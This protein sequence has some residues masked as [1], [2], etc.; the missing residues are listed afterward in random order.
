[1]YL[2][3]HVYC[4]LKLW[5]QCRRIRYNTLLCIISP[6]LECLG[7]M[8][9]RL[10]LF[11]SVIMT[12]KP[13]SLMECGICIGC[14]QDVHI[15]QELFSRPAVINRPRSVSPLWSTCWL[16]SSPTKALGQAWFITPVLERWSTMGRRWDVLLLLCQVIESSLLSRRE[17]ETHSCTHFSLVLHESCSRAGGFKLVAHTQTHKGLQER[18]VLIAF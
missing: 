16:D 18:V 2:A 3:W 7:K 12:N 10:L 11:K 4:I 1:M 15:K 5:V 14:V 6:H 8:R 17:R 13:V 9:H